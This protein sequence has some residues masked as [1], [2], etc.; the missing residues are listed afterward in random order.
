MMERN[1][2]RKYLRHWLAHSNRP[3]LIVGAP[4]SG[5][6][7]FAK[8]LES[9]PQLAA[10][11]Y[12]TKIDPESLESGTVLRNIAWQL[13]NR[14]PNL[15]IPKLASITFLAHQS[16]ALHHFLIKPL[17]SLPTPKVS[18]FIL[19]DG[20]QK[21]IIPLIIQLTKALPCWLKLV[22]TSRTLNENE[23]KKLDRFLVLNIDENPDELIDF[24][25]EKLPQ[26]DSDSAFECCQG[27]W[28]Y[29]SQYSRALKANLLTLPSTSRSSDDDVVTLS[30]DGQLLP[31]GV[32][33]LLTAIESELPTHLNLYLR[34]IAASRRP[35]T[36]QRLVA[37]TVLTANRPANLVEADLREC[38]PILECTDPLILSGAWHERFMGNECE[39]GH[40]LWAQFIQR[41]GCDTLQTLIEFAY[42]LAHSGELHY[43]DR[44]RILREFGADM[45]ELK[46]PVFDYMTTDLLVK[47]GAVIL[48]HRQQKHDFVFACTSGDS[49]SVMNSLDGVSFGELC[50]G[51]IAASS[52][53]HADICKLILQTDPQAANY[54]DPQQWNALRSAACNNHDTVVDLLIQ[55]G[56]EVDECGEGGRTALR[57]AAWSG[58]ER[59]VRRLLKCG[60]DVDR[61]DSE[62]RT[63]LMAAA[64]M[65]HANVV[66][67]LL[68]NG[69]LPNIVDSYG[70]TALHLALSSGAQ[71]FDHDETFAVLIKGGSDLNIED[72]NGRNCLHIAAYHGDKNLPTI[73]DFIQNIDA[74]DRNGRTSLMLASSQGHLAVCQQ[75]IERGAD[76]DAIDEFGRTAL[77]IAA[78]SGFLDVCEMLINSGADE[79]HKDND[80]AVALHY[81]V[82][83]ADL[84]L[85]KSLITSTTVQATDTRGV[86][87][88]LIAGQR[89]TVQVVEELLK[90]GA[91]VHLQ[92]HDG[93]SP[94]RA[95]AISRNE[96]VLKFLLEYLQKKGEGLKIDEPDLDGV[97]LIHTLL[98]L[99][100]APMVTTLLE[101]GA[102]AN[103]RDS[104]GRSC[105]HIVAQLNDLKLAATV[106]NYGADFEARDEDGR[107]PLMIAVWASNYKICHY[108]LETIGVAPNVVDYQGATALNIAANNGQREIVMLLLKFGAEPSICDNLGRCASDVAQ[109]AGH[110]HIRQILKS[111]SGSADSSGFGSLPSS[112]TQQ[113]QNKFFL[114]QRNM[115]SLKSTNN[116]YGITTKS[117]TLQIT[118]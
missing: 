3:L 79:G 7:V 64:F 33:A 37:A 118:H 41:T 65:D 80:G 43:L 109:L 49:T 50:S 81:A 59:V 117:S 31:N 56:M 97:P 12:C 21:E 99:R 23:W 89:S 58:H 62:G 115:G 60:A 52:R 20:I 27:S 46:C 28:F 14:F 113:S 30:R 38:E 55:N 1:E 11:H 104:H 8:S 18:S 71:T 92:S 16:S 74:Q 15:V 51:L 116:T 88:L 61:Q 105:A 66:G 29:V 2:S 107:T 9:E 57:A 98:V 102:S 53:G 35:P 42:H 93:L 32:S 83:H 24:I 63:A 75:L 73:I 68:E 17:Q 26:I 36:R 103:T 40:A 106:R 4:Y 69:A 111:A 47:A 82:A 114:Q 45:I 54:V 13:V 22:V 86:H 25:N 6:T 10:I 34:L 48:D 44:I 108:M 19:I 87:P 85:C 96:P 76:T 100:D 110:D 5:K 84:Q 90:A 94:L 91:P 67:I 39:E 95:A 101:Y 72:M 77:I 112:P 70:S 78:M